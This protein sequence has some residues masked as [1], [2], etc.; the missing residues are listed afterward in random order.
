M[1][2]YINGK[3][4]HLL[5]GGDYNPE[6]WADEPGALEQ[7]MEFMRAAFCNEMTVG[8]FAWPLLEPREGEYDFSFFD[9]VLDRI[10]ENG[11]RVILATPSGSRP[12]WLVEKYP[13]VMRVNYNGE[14]LHFRDRHNHCYTSPVYRQKVVQIDTKLA[15]RY[16]AHPA[17]IAWHISNEYGGHCYC[18][19]CRKAFTE[20][21][22]KRYNDDIQKLNHE[23]W[24]SFWGLQYD[25]FE[26]IEPPTDV[27]VSALNALY[28]DWER[29]VSEQTADFM[30][31]EI[32]AVKKI[33]PSLPVTTNLM[34]KH[35]LNY[36]KMAEK[37]DFVSWDA[38]PDWDDPAKAAPQIAFWHDLF[39]SL[40]FRPF[41]MM[42]SAL[43]LVNWKP[44]NKLKRPDIDRLQS[45]Q[46]IAHGSDSVQ[47]FQFR[48]GRG[49]KEK[50]HGAIVDH[51][52]TMETRIFQVAREI[53]ETVRK[54]DEVAGTSVRS[55]VAIVFDRENSWAVQFATGFNNANKKYTETC[56]AYYEA[57]WKR[58]INVD[59]IDRSGDFSRYNFI[60]AP[61]LYSVD[62]QTIGRINEY[63]KRG[64][65]FYATYMLGMV[66]E[67]DLCYL[68][69]FPGNSLKETFGIWNEEID[70]LYPGDRLRI[71][72]DGK[73]YTGC[74]YCEH[75]HLRGA[76]CLAT[77][78]SE[79]GTMPALTVYSFGRGKAYYQAFRDAGPF[80]AAVISS[81]LAEL[82]IESEIKNIPEGFSVHTREDDENVYVF[83][84]NY[85][86]QEVEIPLAEEYY[87]LI[88]REYTRQ[89]RPAPHSIYVLKKK[90]EGA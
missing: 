37:V 69:G 82:H 24:A 67:N 29:F 77:V 36:W 61:M 89:I 50:F 3:Y 84:E 34:W 55:K 52:G 35:H 44:I 12:R 13:E 73:E 33:C 10:Y 6:Q 21:L 26:Q 53:G 30:Q 40:K 16:G 47:Y 65:H 63:V 88:R 4:P 49:G 66:N 28:I 86:E 1:K 20:F 22:R 85:T 15:E 17:V 71:Y 41:L 43:G 70:S 75:I 19:L 11:G 62:A 42:E 14:R 8:I 60:I 72:M 2:D 46:A 78:E 57:C 58:G 68:G 59:I 81:L 25:R 79:F 56:E 27:S 83:L 38:Y 51:A 54:I 39:R 90:K 87:D 76:K 23:Y 7:D 74:D 45:L 48:K 80:K 9:G 64:G 31:T 18:P 5:H 32:D